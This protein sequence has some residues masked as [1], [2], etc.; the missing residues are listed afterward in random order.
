M[1]KYYVNFENETDRTWSMAIYQTIP[2][3][4]GLDSVAWKLTT[5]PQSGLSGVAWEVDYNVALANYRQDTPLGVYHASQTMGSHLGTEWDIVYRDGV[6]QLKLVGE[7]GLDLEDHILINNK[8]GLTASPGIGMSRAGSVFKRDILSNASAQFKVQPTY[9][10][11]L[12]RDVRLGEVISSN[13]EVGPIKLS[14]AEGANVA[15]INAKRIGDSIE[16]STT[17]SRT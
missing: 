6:Q 12:V 15:T 5:V 8:S 11:G 14:F 3:S 16:H 2:N 10:A 9:W 7:L 1:V 4:I 13:I 17:F